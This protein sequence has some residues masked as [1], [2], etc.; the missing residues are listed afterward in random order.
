[1]GVLPQPPIAHRATV[2]PV[3]QYTLVESMAMANWP[4]CAEASVTAG[5]PAMGIFIT[6]PAPLL[7]FVQY[8]FVEST[9]MFRGWL[10]P[11]ASVV[12]TSWG[13]S[14]RQLEPSRLHRES[15]S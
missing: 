12:G 6:V 9:A 10:W 8:T 11:E 1:M 2:L 14:P 5:P 4:T 3:A 15:P 13:L 7:S